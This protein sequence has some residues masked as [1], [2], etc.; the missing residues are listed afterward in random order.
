MTFPC[1]GGTS[2]Q[3]SGQVV[4]S[5]ETSMQSVRNFKFDKLSSKLLKSNK[6]YNQSPLLPVSTP[7][8]EICIR[9]K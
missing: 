3:F 6:N 5:E 2:K 8:H 7:D 9:Q 1:Q 4:V